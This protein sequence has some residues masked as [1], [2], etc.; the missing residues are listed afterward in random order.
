MSRHLL[1]RQAEAETEEVRGWTCQTCNTMTEG[2]GPH[3]RSCASYWADVS[4][5]LFE[6]IYGYD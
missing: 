3:C 1:M 4:D 2:D 6:E 5:G